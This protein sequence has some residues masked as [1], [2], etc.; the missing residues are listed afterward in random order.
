MNNNNGYTFFE[1]SDVKIESKENRFV[2]FDSDIAHSGTAATDDH[3][4]VINL[5]GLMQQL[6][7]FPTVFGHILLKKILTN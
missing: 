1:N 4:F 7:L 6:L 3:R 5:I 2:V